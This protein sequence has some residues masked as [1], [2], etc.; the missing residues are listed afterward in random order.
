VR[1]Y[2]MVNMA[3]DGNPMWQSLL[4][5]L[6]CSA[7]ISDPDVHDAW[8]ERVDPQ[9]GVSD[10]PTC[11][12]DCFECSVQRHD[13]CRHVIKCIKRPARSGVTDQ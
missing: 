8:H 13:I 9:S 6:R 4:K 7:Y 2:Q 10:Q 1:P 3:A 5:C 12:C 11:P